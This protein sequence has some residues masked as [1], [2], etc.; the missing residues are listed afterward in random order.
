MHETVHETE[1]GIKALINIAKEVRK[2]LRKGKCHGLARNWKQSPIRTLA[3]RYLTYTYG[4]EPTVSTVYNLIKVLNEKTATPPF[5]TVPF[6]ATT[7][8]SLSYTDS[9]SERVNMTRTMRV[10]GKAFVTPTLRAGKITVGNPAEWIWENIPYSFVVDWFLNVGRHLTALDA[11]AGVS[12]VVGYATHRRQSS[13]V[14]SDCVPSG[15]TEIRPCVISYKEYY[16]E[17]F[18]TP[19]A[20]PF[21]IRY[22]PTRSVRALINAVALLVVHAK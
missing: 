6:N 14:V 21:E 20:V 13:A 19:P 17:A 15:S 22:T 3:E 9:Y 8:D 4:I 12:S 5:V 16:R 1:K 18:T 2:C 10:S 7:V 11:Y